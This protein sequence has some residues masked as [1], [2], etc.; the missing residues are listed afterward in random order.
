MIS[1]PPLVLQWDN[2]KKYS[3]VDKKAFHPKKGER[4]NNI[5]KDNYLI[6]LRL[7]CLLKTA[8]PP[9][10]ME[11]KVSKMRSKLVSNSPP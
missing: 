10:Q 11:P 2:R 6:T 4:L 7:N 1:S 5:S 3:S 9:A 8:K